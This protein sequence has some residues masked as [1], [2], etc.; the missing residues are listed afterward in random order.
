M[1]SVQ[2]TPCAAGTFA[3][4]ERLG[5]CLPCVAGR[6]QEVVG[7]TACRA[8][9][10]GAYCRTGAAAALPCD[11]GTYSDATDLASAGQC[12]PCPPHHQCTT[13][14]DAPRPCEPGSHAP[15]PG[16]WECVTCPPGSFQPVAGEG[17]HAFWPP[18]SPPEQPR[19]WSSPPSPPAAVGRRLSERDA[20]VGPSLQPL[21]PPRS[22]PPSPPSSPSPACPP[23][24]PPP[25]PPPTS[26]FSPQV[27]PLLPGFD[28]LDAVNPSFE[29]FFCPSTLR[30]L[31]WGGG[32][33]QQMGTISWYY[34]YNSHKC[35][36]TADEIETPGNPY[37]HITQTPSWCAYEC[38]Y[39][40]YNVPGT[41]IKSNY[42]DAQGVVQPFGERKWPYPSSR[43]VAERRPCVGFS[44]TNSSNRWGC[45]LYNAKFQ[46]SD[47]NPSVRAG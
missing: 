3:D 12:L 40:P 36:Y 4:T 20:A 9:E 7:A 29:G 41:A 39:N 17:I 23:P 21:S 22:S 11:R 34:T 33:Q 5:A 1:G 42:T 15:Y 28:G 13:G 16:S 32:G 45:T 43:G 30:G 27:P 19:R 46:Y 25:A 38:R 35:R 44:S 24:A 47:V 18:S 37:D 6:Y 10:R 14:S 2:P 31:M 26:P 8:C